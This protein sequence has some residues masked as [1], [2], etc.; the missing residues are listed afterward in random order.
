LPYG[1]EGKIIADWYGEGVIKYHRT[2]SGL[3][4]SLV[5]NGFN[6]VTVLEPLPDQE[7]LAMYPQYQEK[8]DY[9]DYLIIKAQK[10]N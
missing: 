9:S 8:T 2:F 10:A 6:I 4:N 7:V 1:K 5:T 3:V